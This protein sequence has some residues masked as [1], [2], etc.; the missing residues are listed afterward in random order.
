MHLDLATD[1]VDKADQAVEQEEAELHLEKVDKQ[2]NLAHLV[3]QV[4]MVMVTMVVLILTKHLTLDLVEVVLA[5][6][7]HKEVTHVKHLEEVDVLVHIL[8]VQ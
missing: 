8:A 7:E 5:V 1:L 4:L 2:L 3:N 6:A